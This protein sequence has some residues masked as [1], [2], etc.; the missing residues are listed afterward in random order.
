MT[1]ETRLRQSPAAPWRRVGADVILAPLG[2][3]DFDVLS[4]SGAVIW[5]LL[6]QPC[7]ESE[8]VDA[9]AELYHVSHGQ[10]ADDVRALVSRLR[11]SGLIQDD[12]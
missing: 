9:L 4:G 10:I 1:S 2:R 5:E 11:Q 6:E 8:L 3:S 12:G 7:A